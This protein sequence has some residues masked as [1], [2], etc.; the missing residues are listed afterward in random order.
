[1]TPEGHHKAMG[2][3]K[4]Y[5]RSSPKIW[6]LRKCWHGYPTSL[7]WFILDPNKDLSKSLKIAEVN[8]KQRDTGIITLALAS[9]NEAL[10]GLFEKSC[11]R[12]LDEPLNE[13]IKS[14]AS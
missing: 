6:V 12:V 4:R 13:T 10:S 3:R 5:L 11:A 7:F 9:S 8:L 14:W 2:L 1:M